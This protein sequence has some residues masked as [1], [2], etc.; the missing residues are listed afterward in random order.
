VVHLGRERR[1]GGFGDP[2]YTVLHHSFLCALI[3]MKAGFSENGVVHA[4]LHDAHEA[5]TVAIQEIPVVALFPAFLPPVAADSKPH[6]LRLY[7]AEQT[8]AVPGNRVTVITVFRQF[9]H[10][11]AANTLQEDEP[12]VLPA[13]VATV[14]VL[15]RIDGSIPAGR[16]RAV[17]SARVWSRI[18]VICPIIAL[19]PGINDHISAVRIRTVPAAG[20]W[21]GIG[22]Q[23]TEV[24]FLAL[25]DHTV[26]ADSQRNFPLLCSLV[27]DILRD[28]LSQSTPAATTP[29]CHTKRT[30]AIA[31]LYV[32]V[33]TLLIP[34]NFSVTAEMFQ[35]AQGAAPITTLRVA[36]VTLL[37]FTDNSVPAD[38][39]LCPGSHS[40]GK[41]ALCRTGRI[42]LRE[43]LAR[44][45][46]R[47]VKFTLTRI[48]T[49]HAS[50]GFVPLFILLTG[51][52]DTAVEIFRAGKFRIIAAAA[53]VIAILAGL[54][55][56]V[57][58]PL[59]LTDA[60]A[61]IVTLFVPII[62]LLL[63]H[64]EKSIAAHSHNYLF[65]GWDCFFLSL[66]RREEQSLA[67]ADH[68]SRR[69]INFGNGAGI[70][71]ADRLFKLR[72][73]VLHRN[74]GRFALLEYFRGNL[75]VSTVEQLAVV[76][77]GTFAIAV[78]LVAFLFLLRL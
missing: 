56:S 40:F 7:F 68:T 53:A 30:A 24:T 43:V 14:T 9:P 52:R 60:T 23:G 39:L 10:A 72:N 37:S 27:R 50:A 18:R 75:A 2:A 6:D 67:P 17:L 13:V 31:I 66:A 33:I 15:S 32:P 4:L 20:I 62:T 61:T 16:K 48:A 5:A 63:W 36:V 71:A 45:E 73:A 1:W 46:E 78:P 64:L 26:S 74:T 29:L 70:E 58:A 59:L 19:F 47:T 21:R 57:P 35:N 8:A 49:R 76:R 44:T 12:A 38:V 54:Y 41:S 51:K 42:F 28:F 25:L 65:R 11:I 77:T 22:I 34:F 55:E 69:G 3:W